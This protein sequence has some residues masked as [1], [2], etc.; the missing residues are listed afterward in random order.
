MLE[1]VDVDNIL[2]SSMVSSGEKHYKYFT[3]YKDDD[4]KIKALR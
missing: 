4:Y 2:I 3:G 1:D